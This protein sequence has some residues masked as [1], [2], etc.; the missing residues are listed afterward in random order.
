MATTH[1]TTRPSAQVVTS[2]E[3][4]V[5]LKGTLGKLTQQIIGSRPSDKIGVP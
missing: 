1:R 3:D 4:F 2:L 5:E